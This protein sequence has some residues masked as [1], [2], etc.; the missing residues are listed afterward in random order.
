VARRRTRRVVLAV[1]LVF[2]VVAAVAIPI[3]LKIRADAATQA[4]RSAA[5]GFARAWS[6]GSLA[7]VRFSGAGG[8]DAAKRVATATAGL[9]SAAKD[10]PSAVEVLSVTQPDQGASRARL[11]V[12][13]TLDG[14]RRWSYETT[15]GLADSGGAWSVVWAPTLVHPALTGSA[16]LTASRTTAA[17][18]RILGA[19]GQVLAGPRDVVYVGIQPGATRDRAS[20]AAQVAA[21][22]D[23]DAGALT[24]A[25]QAAKP[26]AFVDVITLRTEA[27]APLATKLSAIPGVVTRRGTLSLGRTATFARALLGSVGPATKETVD[28]SGGRVQATDVTGLSGLQRTYDARLAGTPGLVVKA[29]TTVVLNAPPTAGK[30]VTTTLDPSVQ[31][32][33]EKALG[34]ATKPA[35]LVA[36][37]PSTGDV[38]AVAN[39]GPNAAGYDRALLG[40]YPPGSTFKVVSGYALLR[41]GYTATTP[42]PCPPSVT[43]EGQTIHNAENE[44]LGT[45]PFR[46]DFAQSCNSAFVGSRTKIS[47]QQLASAAAALG[48]G[49]PDALGVQAFGGSVPTTAGA[50]E[51]GVDMI[52]QGKV[53]ASPLTVATVSASVAAGARVAPRLV[54]DPAPSAGAAARTPLDKGNVSTLQ[55]LMRAVVTQGTGTALVGV[56]GGA[57]H[58]KT[59]TAEFGSKDPPDTHAWFTGYQGD[60][61]FAVIVEGG[62]FGAQVAAPL[63]ADFLTRLHS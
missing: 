24:R 28:A 51:H 41:Q 47:P 43:I 34:A 3:G 36:I 53:L 48:Y 49:E 17:R 29:G 9:T 57:V 52:G 62:G 20:A 50:V 63:A 56:P 35:A 37:R 8:A 16:T 38:V 11:R 23:V 39:G 42:V 1:L 30:D 13:W 22:V 45:V 44:V 40:Q 60:L 46:T 59:G 14:G 19:G 18:G 33:A 6:T 15:A 2:A 10:R 7:S 61:A 25:V 21:L 58:G 32:A 26:T 54:V 31:D 12:T 4:A 5:E 55:D 27:Y